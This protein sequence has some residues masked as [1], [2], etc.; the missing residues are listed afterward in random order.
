MKRRWM[1]AAQIG[2]LMLMGSLPIAGCEQEPPETV[3]KEN[4]ERWKNFQTTNQKEVSAA[5]SA[6]EKRQQ[7]LAEKKK[8]GAEK[9]EAKAAPAPKE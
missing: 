5:M 7:Q 2:L 3:T 9:P 8:G 6:Y 1:I 4:E